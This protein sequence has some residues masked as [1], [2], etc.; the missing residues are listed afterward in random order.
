MRS[1]AVSLIRGMAIVGVVMVHTPQA[2]DG[3]CQTVKDVLSF[4]QLGC[5]SFFVLSAYCLCLS[6]SDNNI[7][8]IGFY[9]KRFLSMAPAYWTTIMINLIIVFISTLLLGHKLLPMN[10]NP[11][12]IGLNILLLHGLLP[13]WQPFNSVVMG[14]WFVGTMMIFYIIFPFLLKVYYSIT[15]PIWQKYRYVL[16]PVLV[17]SLSWSLMIVSGKGQDSYCILASAKYFHF[18]NQIPA[19]ALGISLFDMTKNDEVKYCIPKYF[20][21]L[22]IT[23][24]IF[25]SDLKFANVVC[26]TLISWAT[27]YLFLYLDKIIDVNLDHRWKFVKFLKQIG[28]SSY[29]IYLSHFWIMF[30]CVELIRDY[31]GFDR[32]GGNPTIAYFVLLPILLVFTYYLSVLY[33][34]LISFLNKIF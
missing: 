32:L 18:I 22:F 5:Q 3:I 9:K 28:D 8:L 23:I 2:F 27:L 11:L 13:L 12:Y 31:I 16:F 14:G 7:P 19:F 15:N 26:P 34:K 1:L 29:S 10:I 30:C 25:Y 6:Y 4:G 33:S 20:L 17:T 21:F 24:L